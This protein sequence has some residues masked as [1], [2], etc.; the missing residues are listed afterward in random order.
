MRHVQPLDQADH[1]RAVGHDL[2]ERD[3]GRGLLALG[4]LERELQQGVLPDA[5]VEAGEVETK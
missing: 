5:Q 1:A 3:A 2:A 4:G